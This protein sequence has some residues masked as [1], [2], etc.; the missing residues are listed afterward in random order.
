M[1]KAQTI[2]FDVLIAIAIFFFAAGL[3]FYTSSWEVGKKQDDKFEKDVGKSVDVLSSPQNFSGALVIGSKVDQEK[4]YRLS[5][6]DYKLLKEELG[7][8]WD[9]CIYFE[10]EKGNIVE[11]RRGVA[12]IGAREV[13]VGGLPCSGLTDA[14]IVICAEAEATGACDRL[15]EFGLT[16]QQCCSAAEACCT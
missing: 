1:A 13:L 14:E 9:F 5:A 12:G 16:P 6:M 4:L 2:S 15:T 11:L 8:Q 7:A 3:L 10:D